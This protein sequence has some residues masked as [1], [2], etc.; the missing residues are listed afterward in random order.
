MGPPI[1]LKDIKHFKQLIH[2]KFDFTRISAMH[3]MSIKPYKNAFEKYK[4]VANDY[5]I[6]LFFCNVALNDACLDVA[7]ALKKPAVGFITFLTG[8]LYI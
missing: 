3:D 4:N 5:N 1:N 7:H 6:D 8:K 2:E